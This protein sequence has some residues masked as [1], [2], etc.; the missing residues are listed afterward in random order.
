MKVLFIYSVERGASRKSPISLSQVQFG[1]SYISAMLKQDGHSTELLLLRSEREESSLAMVMQILKQR[2]PDVVALTC[3]SSQYPFLD[4][5]A[6]KIRSIRQDIYLA[7]GGPYVSL[8]PEVAAA[9]VYDAVCIGEGE[10]PMRELIAQ[11]AS[12]RR[13]SGIRNLWL[14][15]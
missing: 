15:R 9:S 13:P 8:N 7:I 6:R 2:S 12:G 4:R 1:I 11:L 3:V 10:Y 5:V 14:R